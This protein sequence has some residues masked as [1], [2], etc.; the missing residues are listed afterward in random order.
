MQNTT[1]GSIAGQESR[2][3]QGSRLYTMMNTLKCVRKDP[4]SLRDFTL[5]TQRH[6]S[7][8]NNVQALCSS[9]SGKQIMQTYGAS[10]EQFGI[11]L[12]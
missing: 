6:E 7:G 5:F 10:L 2:K 4:G 8:G 9:F 11:S 12:F 1:A 3:G